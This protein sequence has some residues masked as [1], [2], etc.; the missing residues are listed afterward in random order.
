MPEVYWLTCLLFIGAVYLAV[1]GRHVSLAT[2]AGWILLGLVHGAVVKPLFVYFDLPS[3]ELIDL[4]LFDQISRADYWNFGSALLLVYG[5]FV[6]AMLFAGHYGQSARHT[7]GRYAV[8]FSNGVL[9][10]FVLVSIIGAAGLFIQH[11]AL[12]E[13]GNKN[14]IATT[15]LEDYSSGGAFRTLAGFSYIVSVL[16]IANVGA[17]RARMLDRLVGLGSATLWLGFCYLSDQR[18]TIVLSIVS[19]VLAYR[20]FVRPLSRKVIAVVAVCV[21][22]VVT[23]RTVGRIA[24]DDAALPDTL[25]QVFANAIGRNFV[26]NGKTI[27]VIQAVPD[28]IDFQYGKSYLDAILI[29]VPREL[30][31]AKATVNLDTVV[32]NAVFGCG[33]FGACAVPPGLLAESYLN[34]GIVGFV[35]LPVLIG[36]VTG[37]LD[38]LARITESRSIYGVLYISTL[39]FVGWSILGSGIASVITQLVVQCAATVLVYYASKITR[40]APPAARPTATGRLHRPLN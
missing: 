33:S 12:L 13:T 14:S 20:R 8:E 19:Y 24:A 39:I 4:T 28:S 29:L 32:G 37:W 15:D 16:S 11:P 21:L 36:L 18:G 6:A 3:E 9:A 35:I 30:F 5:L 38:R 23:V 40:L 26:E 10:I 1:Q 27:A 17:R 25:A 2:G 22:A 7:A 34:F 31:P